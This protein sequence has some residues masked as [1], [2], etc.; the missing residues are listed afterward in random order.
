MKKTLILFLSFF[1]PISNAYSMTRAISAIRPYNFGM[2]QK[3]ITQSEIYPKIATIAPALCNNY[4]EKSHFN[5]NDSPYKILGIDRNANQEAIKKAYKSLSLQYHPDTAQYTK[6]DAHEDMSYINAAY[7]AALSENEAQ[8]NNR[9]SAIGKRAI[10]LMIA[11]ILMELNCLDYISDAP[12]TPT[13]VLTGNNVQF[14]NYNHFNN[15]NGKLGTKR[16]FGFHNITVNIPGYEP[17]S[18]FKDDETEYP[19]NFTLLNKFL[20]KDNK[21]TQR[22][23]AIKWILPLSMAFKVENNQ[24][25]VK[26][27]IYPW[28]IATRYLQSTKIPLTPNGE[29]I[30]HDTINLTVNGRTVVVNPQQVTRLNNSL[31]RIFTN[32]NS[33][34]FF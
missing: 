1:I 21:L 2:I 23:A 22:W 16:F 33:G 31:F 27:S 19:E 6:A 12:I 11:L 10:I 15:G 20:S 28:K 29:K 24:L 13:S 26:S 30:N 9:K 4:Q 34:L 17:V 8:K 7:E 14:L 3:S 32:H 5:K 25:I 18:L